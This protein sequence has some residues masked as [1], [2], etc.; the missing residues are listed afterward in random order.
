MLRGA[1][2]SL[3]GVAI[4]TLCACGL[5]K[6]GL[7][8]TEG[9]IGMRGGI[10]AEPAETDSGEGKRS[11][12]GGAEGRDVHGADSGGAR[13]ASHE[14]AA[15]PR[16]AAT[17]QSDG[18]VEGTTTT[19]NDAAVHDAATPADAATGEV[20]EAGPPLPIVYNGGEI[21]DP[22]FNEAEW[23]SLCVAL[24]ACGLVQ[25]M[26]GC[27]QRLGQPASPDV[28]V[29]SFTMINAIMNA[30]SD[31][32]RIHEILGDGAP[33]SAGVAD[34]CSGNS[35]VTCR[36]GFRLTA[37]CGDFGMTCSSGSGNAG[38]GFGDCSGSQEGK[39]YCVGPSQLVQCNRGRY[40]PFL[41]CQ[42]F[43]A[44]CVGPDETASCQ[45]TAGPG[46]SGAPV[47][48]GP[49]I[50]EC[51]DG[52]LAGANC[53]ALYG[54]GF[55]CLSNDAGVPICASGTA[56]DPATYGD[57]CMG[58]NQISF[59]NAGAITSYDCTRMGWTGGCVA[60]RCVP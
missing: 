14:S 49:M 52:Y 16:D 51:M 31:C 27:A 34:T 53:D 7:L 39:T 57:A 44:N 4:A 18:P 17:A 24:T 11:G 19:S 50:V 47:C 2:Q 15:P 58:G 55:T 35:L 43:G 54:A 36:W 9:G 12:T 23:S 26:S 33:C 5:D 22:K 1:A 42:T 8:D 48:K 28:L 45:G 25:S 56:C 60:G 40:R 10:D 46:C 37:D 20:H 3:G 21:V 59:C 29:P 6:N 30:G 32:M 41:D 38:C 13:D